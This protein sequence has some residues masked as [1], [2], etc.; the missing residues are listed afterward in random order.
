MTTNIIKIKKTSIII[1]EV[2]YYIVISPIRTANYIKDAQA[3][4]ILH[5]LVWLD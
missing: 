4:I 5:T 2:I 1:F 3:N